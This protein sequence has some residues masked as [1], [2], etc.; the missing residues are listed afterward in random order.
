MRS[1]RD[2]ISFLVL[3]DD[4][5]EHPS[6][7]QHLFRHISQRY[8]VLWVNTIG[9]RNPK[10]D[11]TDFHKAVNKIRKMLGWSGDRI[12]EDLSRNGVIACQPPMLPF[13]KLPSVRQINKAIVRKSVRNRL[14]RLGMM[15]PV[16][17][18]TVPN[19][20]DYIGDLGESKVI[21]YCVDDFSEWPGLEKKMVRRME[22]ELIRKSDSMVAT[23]QKLFDRLSKFGKPAYLMTHGVD[24]GLFKEI[25]PQEHPALDGIPRPRIGYYGLFDERSD[26]DLLAQLAQR[27][28]DVSFVITGQVESER[29]RR[30]RIPNVH[31]T[32]S[33]PYAEL[34]AMVKG[35]DV[36][37]LPY[38]IN[39]LTDAISPLKLKE[40]LAAGKQIVSSPIPEVLKLQEYVFI[41]ETAEEW[42]K[43][44]RICLDRPENA[45]QKPGEDFWANETWEQKAKQFLNNV[46]D[47][48]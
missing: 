28:P 44:L 27:M 14:A 39:D 8:K 20:C 9:M 13:P 6:S 42:E 40:Y 2:E 23:S 47:L 34:P 38:V 4:W 43:S 25:A 22:D 10:L 17:V 31:F 33:V 45:K 11:S 15:A 3:S 37:I 36:L 18:A 16:L 48:N 46:R 41:A 1:N 5:G 24:T 7:C 32:G 12:Q 35:W 30:R 19:A 21:Y 29:L 26:H